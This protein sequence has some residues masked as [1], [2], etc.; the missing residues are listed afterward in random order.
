M[1]CK[2]VLG[3]NGSS[4]GSYGAAIGGAVGGIV[5]FVSIATVVLLVLLYVRRSHQNKSYPIKTNP[6]SNGKHY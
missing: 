6:T 3:V 5:G 2:F 4:E 1:L